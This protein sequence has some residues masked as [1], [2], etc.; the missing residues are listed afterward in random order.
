M[1]S[2][3]QALS[4]FKRPESGRVPVRQAMAWLLSLVVDYR[5]GY[6]LS[7]TLNESREIAPARLDVTVRRAT[8]D[9]LDL[10]QTIAPALRIRR[11]ARKLGAGEI[12]FIAIE[13]YKETPRIVGFVWAAFTD[14]PT[15]GEDSVKLGPQEAYIWGGYVVPE[16]RRY[17]L[18]TILGCSLRLWLQD[19]GYVSVVLFV[20]RRNGAILAHCLKQ[21]YQITAQVSFLKLLRC[22]VWQSWKCPSLQPSYQ[23]P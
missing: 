12:C 14:S 17:G 21:G 8:V 23:L 18:M 10:F 16:F 6:C 20:K 2:L 9:D 19:Q 1:R 15:S 22:K 13:K 5:K 11:F 7:K 4:E 3:G